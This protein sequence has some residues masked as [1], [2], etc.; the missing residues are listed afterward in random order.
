[1]VLA[2]LNPV[3]NKQRLLKLLSDHESP[4]VTYVGGSFPLFVSKAKG[5]FVYDHQGR[6]Y[7][8][9]TSFF[10]VCF[11]GHNDA[12]VNAAVRKQ[13][14]ACVHGMGDIHPPAVKVELLKALL[15]FLPWRGYKGILST[16]GSEAMESAI[17]TAL[18]ATGRDELV[19]FRG[20]Y[21]GLTMGALSL[22]SRP[23]FRRS[24][25]GWL[26]R[27]VRFAQFPDLYH[28]PAGCSPGDYVRSRLSDL[29]RLV[30]H[31]TAG[32]VIE[33]IQG[34]GGVRP[35][36]ADFLRGVERLC[37]DRGALFIADEVFTG[38]GRTGAKFAC[39]AA[40][41]RPDII[42]VGKAMGNG[43]PISACLARGEIMDAWGPSAGEGRHTS[44]FLG[45]PIGCAAALAV[46]RK[47]G[48]DR[49][50]LA[51]RR[52]GQKLLRVLSPL[53][54]SPYVGDIR[55]RGL[56][57]GVELVKSKQ[58]RAPHPELASKLVNDA[59]GEG[60]LLLTCGEEGHVLSLTPP[61]TI[62][63]RQIRKLAGF[64]GRCLL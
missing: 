40:G 64:L 48:R 47:Q 20:G 22:T 59:L 44:T 17:K 7:D 31:K 13:M 60:L 49:P 57:A 45:N 12:Q 34:R 2:L 21:H 52:K 8:D 11:L 24:F 28:R 41:V 30:T 19:A 5:A 62:Q 32:V 18:V 14:G 55:G 39:A 43:F 3:A 4:N 56:M 10:G 1:M 61:V 25:E 9:F 42:A 27:R 50:W 46:L 23:L 35:A 36:P 15:A 53:A 54:A 51:A 29:E 37:R 26:S 16:T 58:S 6:R 63:E 38:F 33:P